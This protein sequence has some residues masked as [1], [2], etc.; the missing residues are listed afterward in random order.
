VL[1]HPVHGLKICDFGLS[2]IFSPSSKAYTPEVV[3]LWYRGPELLLGQPTYSSEVD[4]WSA[5]CILAEMATGDPTFPGDSEIGTIFKIMQLLGSPTEA[6][7]PGFE[8]A[9]P[10]W[11]ASFPRW[12]PT[13]LAS[14]YERRPE[15]GSAGMDLLRGMLAMNPASRLTSR[16]AKARALGLAAQHGAA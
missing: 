13:G 11:K 4:I 8:Q 16:R 1:V 14:L 10:L 5:G 9:T 15:L 7:W 6:T 2:R 3:T 12:P